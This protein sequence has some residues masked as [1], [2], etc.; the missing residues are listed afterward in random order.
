MKVRQNKN[1]NKIIMEKNET[2]KCEVQRALPQKNHCENLLPDLRFGPKFIPPPGL[3]LVHVDLKCLA[4]CFSGYARA[5]ARHPL[6]FETKN[7]DEPKGWL[8]KFT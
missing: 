4:A 8:L 1:I 2:K 3:N 6:K 7:C 5:S